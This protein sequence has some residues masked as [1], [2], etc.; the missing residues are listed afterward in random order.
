MASTSSHPRRAT[1]PPSVIE[2]NLTYPQPT[3]DSNSSP[4]PSLEIEDPPS[5]A[6]S[7]SSGSRSIRSDSVLEVLDDDEELDEEDMIMDD[8]EEA[9]L[10]QPLLI[11]PMVLAHPLPLLPLLALLPYN[12]LPAGVVFFVPVLCVLALLSSYLKVSSFEDVFAAVT[13]KYGKY[14]LWGGRAAVVV[15]VVGMLP[16]IQA[17]APN[18][19][20]LSSRV[21][22]TLLT[23]IPLLPSLLPSRMTRSLRRSPI[24]IALLLPVVAFL[25]IGRTVEIK[26]AAELPMPI[27]DENEM[28]T[29]VLGHLVKRRSGLAGG[30]SAGAGL[31]E[32]LC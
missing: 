11:P 13:G 5:H 2:P 28:A 12:F 25:V 10:D 22:W 8:E 31:G 3:D 16:I 19:A 6:S 20:L 23:S 26:K 30:S 17:Y 4:H 29:E 1:P 18:S 7:Q 27:G 21:L 15:G 24:V 14:G 32:F 9:G